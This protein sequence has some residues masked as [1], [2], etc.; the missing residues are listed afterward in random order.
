MG[1]LAAHAARLFEPAVIVLVGH[2]DD[3]LTIGKALGAT[4]TL[5]SNEGDIA[6]LVGELTDGRGPNAVLDC[7]ATPQSMRSA[8][9]IVRPGGVV[10]WVGMGV[11][12][13]PPDI[14]W[15][16]AFSATL[17]FMV[18]CLCP[19]STSGIFGRILRPVASILPRS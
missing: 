8:S 18:A 6:A 5:N 7:V 17:D 2:H 3:R 14:P 19:A 4:H 15:D 13:S 16:V 12:F 1:L 10:S 11:F 9:E